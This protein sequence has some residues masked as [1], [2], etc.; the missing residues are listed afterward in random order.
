LRTLLT[1]EP[2]RLVVWRVAAIGG[3]AMTWAA[4]MDERL[5]LAYGSLVV[6]TLIFVGIVR[7]I[8]EF[9]R[10][11]ALNDPKVWAG[12]GEEDD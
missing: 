1:A 7:D 10:R 2:S 4:I 9:F 12:L 6:H 3:F 11:R 5:V 8:G